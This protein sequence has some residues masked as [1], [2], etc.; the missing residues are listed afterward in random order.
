M[1]HEKKDTTHAG[2]RV[3]A[4]IHRQLLRQLFDEG[5]SFRQ[6]LECMEEY[7]VKQYRAD[8]V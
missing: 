3:D 7:Y 8:P 2:A 4:E 1:E 6:W 5:R